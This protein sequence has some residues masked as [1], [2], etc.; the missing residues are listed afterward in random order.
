MFSIQLKI[1]HKLFFA[2]LLVVA[3]ILA[4]NLGVT[5]YIFQQGFFQYVEAV[6]MQKLEP[7]QQQLQD[8][9]REVGDWEQ[10][11][12][13][14][15]L[16]HQML[17][18]AEL[19]PP[20][21]SPG[22]GGRGFRKGLPP[23]HRMEGEWRGR[24]PPPRFL[25]ERIGLADQNQFSLIGPMVSERQ[26]L[27]PIELDQQ[28][29]GYLVLPKQRPDFLSR[30][31]HRFAEKQLKA[32][33][34][35]ALVSLLVAALSAWWLARLF[36][37]PIRDLTGMAKQLTAGEFESRLQPS[38]RD[39]LGGLAED[40]NYLAETLELNQQSR[41]RWIADIS[42]ELRTPLTVLRGE[43]EALED[44]VRPL[45]HK[46]IASLALEVK[47]LNRLVD[48]LHQLSMADQGA[49]SY[50]KSLHDLQQLLQGVAD[51][52]QPMFEAHALA[53]QFTCEAA[54]WDMLVDPQ[55]MT[56]L[57][58]NLLEN[59][60]R[61]TDSGGQLKIWCEAEEEWV[62]HFEDTAPGVST[63]EMDRLFERLYRVER[64]RNRAEGGSGLGL[65]IVRSI[66]EAHGGTVAAEP[67]PLGGLRITLRLPIT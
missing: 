25:R 29:V 38:S 30:M 57:F 47:Q 60:L 21:P 55:R 45:D 10:L 26:K 6:K 48:D 37:R 19:V 50:E 39:E 7:L 3:L 49:L 61:Y 24:R 23:A 35:I 31:D 43:L 59:S 11:Q 5:R 36:N 8:H 16:W 54:P 62:I 52:F 33:L 42:H 32:F 13:E 12:R 22:R 34:L 41:Q 65:S 9:Y 44:G 4:L 17:V 18:E 14:P 27:L 66:A 67:S 56:Q 51:S 53:L 20:G 1:W 64:S 46:A 58:T 15:F 40:L 63:A 2:I 28:V